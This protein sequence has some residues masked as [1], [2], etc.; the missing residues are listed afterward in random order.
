M[1]PTAG[2]LD[3]LVRGFVGLWP[4]QVLERAVTASMRKSLLATAPEHETTI[5]DYCLLIGAHERRKAMHFAATSGYWSDALSF[6][7]EGG[8]MT[9]I[10]TPRT[11]AILG[12]ELMKS[13]FTA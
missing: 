2:F 5:L 10:V 3:W 9:Q 13:I 12:T 4:G 11:I 8:E 1:A 7:A 6:W